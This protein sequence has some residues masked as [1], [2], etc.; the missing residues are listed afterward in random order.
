MTDTRYLVFSQRPSHIGDADYH[1]WYAVHAQENIASPGFVCAQ[2]YR[3]RE[4][5]GGELTGVERHLAMYEH[6]VPRSVW[7]PNLSDRIK[8]GEL[9]MPDW[10]GEIGFQSWTCEPV[11]PL[12]L[13]S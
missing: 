6:D 5:V 10:F 11:G 1:E 13:P 4:V 2:R 8:A 12:L 9:T 3:A 7:R